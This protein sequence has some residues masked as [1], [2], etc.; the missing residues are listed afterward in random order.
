MK[1]I[2]VLLSLCISTHTLFAQ[3]LYGEFS[4]GFA[5][6]T[7]KTNLNQ[8][9]FANTTE[10]DFSGEYDQ[11]NISLGQ[12]SN[13]KLGLGYMFNQNLGFELGV[14]YLLGST[15]TSKSQYAGD[16]STPYK[17]ERNIS[18]RMLR[19]NPSV[20]VCGSFQRFNPFVK[21][22]VILGK[23]SIKYENDYNSTSE[24][25]NYTREYTGGLALGFSTNLGGYL[26][27]NE[28]ISL[29]FE[30]QTINLT[31][32][33]TTGEYTEY[34][35]NGQDQL[36]IFTTSQKEIEY[37]DNYT[38]D[39]NAPLNSSAPQKSLRYNFAFGSVGLNFGLKINF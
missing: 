39:G 26:I 34:E 18:A 22:G 13:A 23:G 6:G 14:S 20:V 36:P 10:D 16:F 27:L 7:S 15:A 5:M 31:Y 35:L 38:F 17:R 25:I 24:N 32:A 28:S 9:N 2:I 30:L 19:I 21:F 8:L 33:P 11:I 3:G 29:L 12:G 1:K 37:V 4:M